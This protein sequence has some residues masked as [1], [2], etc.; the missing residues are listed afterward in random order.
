MKY[1]LSIVATLLIS[2]TFFSNISD[3]SAW[4]VFL[5]PGGSSDVPYCNNSGDCGLG[6]GLKP[7]EKIGLIE[8]EQSASE[9]IQS[10]VAYI[11]G[12]LM[13]LSVIIIIY[14]GVV[15]LTGAGDEEKAKKTKQIILYAIFGLIIIFLAYPISKFVFTALN[16]GSGGQIQ[17]TTNP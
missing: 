13:L 5:S 4:S 12:F 11:L 14:A 16:S 1:L 9:F 7:L 3:V 6:A 17:N 2:L 10:I 15:L 8:T